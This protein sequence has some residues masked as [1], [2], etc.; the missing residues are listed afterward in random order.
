MVSLSRR[1]CR[2]SA[3]TLASLAPE[4]SRVRMIGAI[5]VSIDRE[6]T[7]FG[8]DGGGGGLKT[9]G[10]P[11]SLRSR[12]SVSGAHGPIRAVGLDAIG[13]RDQESVELG[14]AQSDFWLE[15]DASMGIRDRWLNVLASGPK[16]PGCGVALRW[17]ERLRHRRGTGGGGLSL[18][19]LSSRSMM[20]PSR[21]T[22]YRRGRAGHTVE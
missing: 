7:S 5:L 3:M 20:V 12:I 9:G 13:G 2:R 15:L 11:E 1:D 18:R 17:R 6:I 22:G 10:V 8:E 21:D 4:S 19:R 14:S 16:L